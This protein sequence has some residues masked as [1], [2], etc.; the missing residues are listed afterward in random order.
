MSEKVLEEKRRQRQEEWEKVRKPDQPEQA[1]E[2]PYESRSLFDQLQVTVFLTVFGYCL[3]LL[4][5]FYVQ[6]NKMKAQEEWEEAHKLKN[7]I[8]GIDNDEAEFLDKVDD[9]RLTMERNRLGSRGANKD[10]QRS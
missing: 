10:V 3:Q 7:Q 4:T 6:A 9:Y 8:R 1:P 5:A 2:E